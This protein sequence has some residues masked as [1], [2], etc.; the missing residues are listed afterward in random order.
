VISRRQKTLQP[1]LGDNQNTSIMSSYFSGGDRDDSSHSQDVSTARESSTTLCTQSD[2]SNCSYLNSLGEKTDLLVGETNCGFDELGGVHSPGKKRKFTTEENI[3]I[4]Y[5][6]TSEQPRSRNLPQFSIDYL[7]K[8]ISENSL[9][10]TKAEKVSIMMTTS[11]TANQVGNWFR[12]ARRKQK[13][14]A[15]EQHVKMQGAI[16][17]STVAYP[18]SCTVEKSSN[19]YPSKDELMDIVAETS[20]QQV[21][22]WYRA[23]REE[24]SESQKKHGLPQTSIEYLN[25]WIAQN[26]SNLYPT[27]AQ[28]KEMASESGLTERQVYDWF[29]EVRRKKRKASEGTA[30][31]GR[32]NRQVL[33]Q[34]SVNYLH[35]W[36]AEHSLNPFPT[37]M[38]KEDIILATGLMENQVD[39]W[40]KEARRKQRD[41]NAADL[42][43]IEATAV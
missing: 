38:E 27:S 18:K 40:F 29:R 11:L 41:A 34:Q 19:V 8:W 28:N 20:K 7:Q 23:K 3:N 2:P 24:S 22:D 15:S 33:P 35:N 42:E 6:A 39:N 4:A 31:K 26:P 16:A 37:K 30:F 25:H 14:D 9:Y 36:F 13:K 12:E 5:A 32:P 10:P 21:D 17:N 43:K 1:P